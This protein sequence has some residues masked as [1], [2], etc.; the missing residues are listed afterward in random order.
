MTADSSKP[1]TDVKTPASTILKEENTYDSTFEKASPAKEEVFDLHHK[2]TGI[3][4]IGSEAKPETPRGD[5]DSKAEMGFVVEPEIKFAAVEKMSPTFEE[6]NLMDEESSVS[7]VTKE[8]SLQS[9]SNLDLKNRPS[10]FLFNCFCPA[11]RLIFLLFF[12]LVSHLRLSQRKDDTVV[13]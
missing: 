2:S 3:T 11:N 9:G 1:E 10:I 6:A 12:L 7:S 8:G 13:G 5:F 4:G